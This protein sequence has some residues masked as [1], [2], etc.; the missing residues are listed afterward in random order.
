VTIWRINCL[1]SAETSLSAGWRERDFQRQKRRKPARCQRTTVSG[2][3]IRR[4]SAQR[5]QTRERSS[6]MAR[7][8]GR[9]RCRGVDRRRA[10]GCWR[11]AR[12]SNA[13]S[14]RVRRAERSVPSRL[15]SKASMAGQRMMPCRSGRL[16]SSCTHRRR[17]RLPDEDLAN[18][19]PTERRHRPSRRPRRVARRRLPKRTG[20][21]QSCSAPVGPQE[22]PATHIGLAVGGNVVPTVAKQI[23]DKRLL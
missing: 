6:Q 5:D 18:H 15:R 9:S 17:K 20:A 10:A 7:S 11:R 8:V 1:T 3:T 2:W 21:A 16:Y 12:F 22:L 23:L 14:A 4:A 19:R 13:S